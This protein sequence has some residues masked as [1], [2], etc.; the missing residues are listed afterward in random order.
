MECH[1]T[2]GLTPPPPP[3]EWDHGGSG[4]PEGG[5]HLHPQCRTDQQIQEGAAPPPDCPV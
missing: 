3:S 2:C 1:A 4:P 5:R